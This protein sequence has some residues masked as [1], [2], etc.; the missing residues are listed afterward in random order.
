MDSIASCGGGA[1]AARAVLVDC[2][3][4]GGAWLWLPRAS[5]GAGKFELGQICRWQLK[6]GADARR[7]LQAW[8]LDP[9]DLYRANCEHFQ[10]TAEPWAS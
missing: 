10:N 2:G 9:Q 5:R 3:G 8:Q 1:A 4:G 6:R 7:K